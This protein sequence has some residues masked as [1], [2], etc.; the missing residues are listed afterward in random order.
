M[1]KKVKKIVKRLL[2]HLYSYTA[3]LRINN[4]LETGE[5]NKNR[6]IWWHKEKKVTQEKSKISVDN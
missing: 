4:E 5:L 6:I 3:I 2:A 1:N